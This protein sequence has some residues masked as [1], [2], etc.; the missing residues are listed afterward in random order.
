MI[1]VAES[2]GPDQT[3]RLRRLIWA[4]AVCICPKTSFRMARPIK[5]LNNSYLEDISVY[6]SLCSCLNLFLEYWFYNRKRIFHEN[7]MINKTNKTHNKNKE[8]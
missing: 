7:K 2:E 5:Y 6:F 4:F 8:S 3:V 1:L